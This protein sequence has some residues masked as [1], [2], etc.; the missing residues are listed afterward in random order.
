MHEQYP[1]EKRGSILTLSIRA[2]NPL[3]HPAIDQ[4]GISFIYQLSLIL[5]EKS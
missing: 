1:S 2:K 3:V 5:R 4:W